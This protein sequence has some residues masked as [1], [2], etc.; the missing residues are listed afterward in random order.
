MMLDV[1]SK[2][3]RVTTNV[4]AVEGSIFAYQSVNVMKTEQ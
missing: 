3:H 2:A 1:K 4:L